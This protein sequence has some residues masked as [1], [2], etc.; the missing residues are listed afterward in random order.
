MHEQK[1]TAYCSGLLLAAGWYIS[2]AIVGI[3]GKFV[4]LTQSKINYTTVR[5]EEPVTQRRGSSYLH[6]FNSFLDNSED[7]KKWDSLTWWGSRWE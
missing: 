4:R 2:G 1:K 5:T 7:L 6:D 3:S